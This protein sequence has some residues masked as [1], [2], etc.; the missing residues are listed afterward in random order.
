MSPSTMTSDVVTQCSG[1]ASCGTERTRFFA[2]QLVTPDD[3]T[4]DQIYFRE[5]MRRH[6]R[7]LHGWGIVCGAGV[8]AG[9]G[10]CDVVISAGFILGPYGDEITI[11][12]N[13]TVDLCTQDLDGNAAGGCAEPLD[14]WCSDVTVD[15]RAGTTLFVAIR[16]AECPTRPVR[17][18]GCGC[19]CSSGDCEYSRTRDGYVIK[20]L[21][22]L[23]A[24][25]VNMTPPAPASLLTC[26][27]G[28]PA[29][30]ACPTDPWVILADVTF[31]A[32]GTVGTID[33]AAHRRYVVSLA[34]Q[35]V[36]CP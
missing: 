14:P 16:Y 2:G 25:Y 12:G 3:L 19:G 17:S 32:D 7:L 20:G 15:R 13:V 23:P 31:K 22:A 6:N 30:P 27:G 21:T 36:V 11:E 8:T 34:K 4:Q 26:A 28:A 35:F 18:S 10:A 29:C 5:R 9:T 24:S 33:V 1:T